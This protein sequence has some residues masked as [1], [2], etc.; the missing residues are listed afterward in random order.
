MLELGGTRL[1]IPSL[2][3]FQDFHCRYS[4]TSC[5]ERFNIWRVVMIGSS[6]LGVICLSAI[7]E[8]G[9]TKERIEEGR[10]LTPKGYFYLRNGAGMMI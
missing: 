7:A 3:Y 8:I 4:E 9:P 6:A 10:K 1:E 5:K 2:K